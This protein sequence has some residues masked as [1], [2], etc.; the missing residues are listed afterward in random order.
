MKQYDILSRPNK[1][2]TKD[3]YVVCISNPVWDVNLIKVVND[4]PY[5]WP[6]SL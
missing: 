4:L 3:C 2:L 6:E 5:R 1:L